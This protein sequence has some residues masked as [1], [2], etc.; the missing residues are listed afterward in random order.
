ME[1][2]LVGLGRPEAAALLRPDVDDRR[3]GQLER[4]SE[5]RQQRMEVVSGNRPDVGDAEILEQ[6]AGLGELH[7]HPADALAELEDRPA[8]NRDPL[9]VP[10]VGALALAPRPGQLDLGQVLRERADRRADRHLVVVDHDQHLRLAVADVVERL[11]RQPAHQRGVTDHDGDPLEAVTQVACLGETLRDRQAGAGVPA[12]EHVVRRFGA[13]R[14]AAHPVELAK[15][16]ERL[17]AAGQQLVRI[18]LVTG[19]PDDPVPWRFE[20]PMERD[21]QLDDAERRAQMAARVR[22]RLDDRLPDLERQLRQL[23]LAHPAKV[24]W[25]LDGRKDRHA[26][27]APG[28]AGWRPPGSVGLTSGSVPV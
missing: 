23:D 24:G 21:R 26:G 7:D 8:D 2:D 1:A 5:R 14:E 3:P 28:S 22:H 4:L 17:Q 11:E 27:S 15:R 9:D 10:V 12:V 6:L 16:A 18:G 20:Q 13:P 25:P 19:V